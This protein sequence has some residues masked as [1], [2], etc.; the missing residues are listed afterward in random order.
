MK[1]LSLIT[2]AFICILNN[3]SAT[4]YYV[5]PAGNNTTGNGTSGSQWRTI[6]YAL[7]HVSGP[8]AIIHVAAGK[9]NTSVGEGFPI[10]MK[11][12]VSLIGGPV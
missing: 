6:T 3:I 1:K 8:G 2:V 10:A 12:G 5:S 4:D 9:Y 7:F 11:N